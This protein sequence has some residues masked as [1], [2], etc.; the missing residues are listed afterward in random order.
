MPGIFF[1]RCF[2]SHP[3]FPKAISAKKKVTK[4]LFSF[5]SH[6]EQAS[7]NVVI[8]LP[9]EKKI[10]PPPKKKKKITRPD[11]PNDAFCGVS[12]KKTDVGKEPIYSAVVV[13]SRVSG[14][15]NHFPN[16]EKY[17]EKFSFPWIHEKK[18]RLFPP[19][20]LY[21]TYYNLSPCNFEPGVS[22]HCIFPPTIT[23]NKT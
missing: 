5:F 12:Q 13:A 6:P 16:E 22:V 2:F 15:K 14:G 8:Y 21:P 3:S 19:L 11:F 7:F 4:L 9:P 23:S 1:S 20:P 18:K 17:R 10:P